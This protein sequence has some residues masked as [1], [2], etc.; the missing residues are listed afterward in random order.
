MNILSRHYETAFFFSSKALQKTNYITIVLQHVYRQSDQHFISLLNKIRDSK[1]DDGLIDE[2][3]KRYKPNFDPGDETY[4]ILTTHN[5]K[6]RQV[7]ETKL[8]ALKEQSKHF[9]AEVNGKFPEYAYPT[10]VDLKLKKDAQVMFVKNDPNPE[11]RYFNGKIG[12]IVGFEEDEVIVQCPE[13]KEAIY[14]S[15]IDWDNIKYSVDEETKEIEETVEGTFSQ[16]P[17][18]LAWAITIHKSQGLTFEK[19]IIDSEK[20]FAH[21][22]VYVALSRCRSVSPRAP[23]P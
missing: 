20:A 13:D 8:D 14:V 19:A 11:K 9:E 10:E 15:S 3:N 18:K 22:Q 5:A 21:G 1:I 6:A 17:L 23:R 16:I 7:N 2:L 4:I 12:I